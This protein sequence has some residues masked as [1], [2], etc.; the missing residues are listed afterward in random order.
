[1]Y[2]ADYTEETSDCYDTEYAPNISTI[3]YTERAIVSKEDN[4]VVLK[5]HV[6]LPKPE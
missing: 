6:Y 4:Q 2:F 3:D 1:M 5:G